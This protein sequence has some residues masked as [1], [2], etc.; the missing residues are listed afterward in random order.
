MMGLVEGILLIHNNY[1]SILLIIHHRLQLFM[2]L[3]KRV[4]QDNASYRPFIIIGY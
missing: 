4:E 1:Y 2:V 3:V